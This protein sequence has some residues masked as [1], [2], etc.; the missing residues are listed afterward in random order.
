MS[1]PGCCTRT[2]TTTTT[3]T[4]ARRDAAARCLMTEN[5][6]ARPSSDSRIALLIFAHWRGHWRRCWKQTRQ[7]EPFGALKCPEDLFVRGSGSSSFCLSYCHASCWRWGSSCSRCL[8]KVG[9]PACA[10]NTLP[11]G[12]QVLM[13]HS[14]SLI[15]PCRE[16]GRVVPR[17]SAQGAQF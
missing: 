1:C 9:S 8:A 11:R 15:S 5:I 6:F 17:T 14:V 10:S 4:T 12:P 2:V 16:T 7:R 13:L 3:T